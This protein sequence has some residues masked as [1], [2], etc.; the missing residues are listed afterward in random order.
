MICS[1]Q[2]LRLGLSETEYLYCKPQLLD[3]VIKIALE[4]NTFWIDDFPTGQI[5]PTNPQTL[6]VHYPSRYEL[7]AKAVWLFIVPL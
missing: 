7:V 1:T 4:G 6:F 5:K 2:F 3:E